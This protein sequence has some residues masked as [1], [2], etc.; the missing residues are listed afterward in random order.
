MIE[1]GMGGTYNATGPATPLTFRDLLEH[2]AAA[3]E[4]PS[5]L[6]WVDE[7]FL[8]ERGV[9][10]WTELPLWVPRE[11]A[12]L[13]EVSIQRALAAGLELRPLAETVRDTLAWDLA[14]P[15]AAREGSPAL[16]PEREAELLAQWKAR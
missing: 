11:E 12:G 9:H 16:T 15:D 6:T 8:L 10:P 4:V 7:A 14:R 3:L 13:D 5:R 1:R 2:A